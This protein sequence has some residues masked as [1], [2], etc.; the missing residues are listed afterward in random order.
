[1]S[2]TMINGCYMPYLPFFSFS[3]SLWVLLHLLCP[4]L[5]L[6]LGYFP[7]TSFVQ[8]LTQ[9]GFGGVSVES[10]YENSLKIAMCCL[11]I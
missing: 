6:H 3:F 5:Q 8:S 10:H 7:L 2:T 11:K 4:P 1:M 9:S